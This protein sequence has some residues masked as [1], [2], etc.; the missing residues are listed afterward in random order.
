MHLA[1]SCLQIIQG[2]VA[3]LVFNIVEIHGATRWT[4]DCS[5]KTQ[6]SRRQLRESWNLLSLVSRG[7]SKQDKQSL[8]WTTLDL[9]QQREL[10]LASGRGHVMPLTLFMRGVPSTLLFMSTA[11]WLVEYCIP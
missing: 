10:Q 7:K 5:G 8:S 3:D 2:Q 1:N 11:G 4:E 6:M 9:R